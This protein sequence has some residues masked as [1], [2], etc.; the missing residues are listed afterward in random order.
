[1][2]DIMIPA[3]R[4]VRADAARNHELLLQTAQQLF[5]ERNI[6]DVTMSEIA[7]VAG[8]G[9]GTLYRHFSDKG[10]LCHA[11]LDEAMREFQDRTLQTMRTTT[12]PEQTL[13]QFLRDAIEYVER[14]VELLRA[15][16]LT[17]TV[18]ITEHP[19]HFWWRQTIYA[20]LTQM[21]LDADIDFLSDAIYA[22]LEVRILR[23]FRRAR[24]YDTDRIVS[25][26]SDMIDRYNR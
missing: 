13:K 8:V 17:D 12:D 15:A 1:M 21:K 5:S 16:A 24:S 3:E 22:M 10:D 19:A 2:N 6:D 26:L 9:K 25:G 11:L 23:Y 18:P 7:R 4:P 14:N 20:L